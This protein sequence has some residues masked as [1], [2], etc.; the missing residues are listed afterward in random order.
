[1]FKFINIDYEELL[2]IYQ[3][4]N[5]SL[6]WSIIEPN[7]IQLC[8][9]ILSDDKKLMGLIAYHIENELCYIDKFEVL[10]NSRNNGLGKEIIKQFINIHCCDIELLPLGEDSERFWK[11]CGFVGDKFLL[12]YKYNI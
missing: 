11:K 9:K 8:E 5:W 10:Q 3:I 1:M 6:G 4:Y 7:Q 12:E 2:H